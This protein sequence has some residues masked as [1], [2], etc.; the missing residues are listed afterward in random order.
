L[1]IYVKK[2][3]RNISK[4]KEENLKMISQNSDK[5]T[6]ILIGDKNYN[7]WARQASF[8]LIGQEQLEYVN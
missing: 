4:T 7:I 3:E 2:F 5:L 8:G 6:S 1:T